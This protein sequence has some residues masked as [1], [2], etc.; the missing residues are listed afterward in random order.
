M[1]QALQVTVLGCGTSSGVPTI[2]CDCEVCVSSDPRNKRLRSSIYIQKGDARILVDCGP[3]F[4]QQALRERIRKVDA[5]FITH[6]HA[7]HINGIDD[8]RAINWVQ[9]GPIGVYSNQSFLDHLK[10]AYGYCFN[11][12]QMGGGVPKLE[13]H[14]MIEAVKDSVHGIQVTPIPVFHGKLPILGFRFDDFVYLTDVSRI[15]ESSFPLIE[16][17]HTL[18]LSALRN[19]PH[20]T[21]Y[22]VEQAVEQARAFSPRRTYF[23]HMTHDL[24]YET[25]NRALP[26]DMQLL[27]DGLRFAVP[28]RDA[29]VEDASTA[30]G[31]TERPRA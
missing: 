22:S 2:G 18:V 8:L 11:P 6:T 15:P 24:D 29:E 12:P 19:R 10:C 14:P 13:F 4:R 26:A 5:L 30:L 21:H 3:D 9:K 27:Y 20:E 28:G 16:G 23:I 1:N 31:S 17:A 7:D 25:T